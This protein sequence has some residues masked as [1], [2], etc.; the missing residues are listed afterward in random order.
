MALNRL[1][2]RIAARESGFQWLGMLDVRSW[3]CQWLARD[4]HNHRGFQGQAGRKSDRELGSSPRLRR[5]I[6]G[7]TK[8]FNFARDNVHPDPSAG[9]GIGFGLRGKARLEEKGV[10]SRVAGLLAGTQPAES[11]RLLC[12]AFVI[13]SFPVVVN[14]D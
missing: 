3:Y 14:R 6:E 10:K 12:D 11:P 7:S 9:D 5:E 8:A 13:Q 2:H 1:C 4:A